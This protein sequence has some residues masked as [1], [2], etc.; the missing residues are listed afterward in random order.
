MAPP[1]MPMASTFLNSWHSYNPR[2]G[3]V[4]EVKDLCG[5]NY[6]KYHIYFAYKAVADKGILCDFMLHLTKL[7]TITKMI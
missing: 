4:Q 6:N 5:A 7:E 3:A 2:I 1:E